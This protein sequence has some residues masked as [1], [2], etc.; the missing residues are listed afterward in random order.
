MISKRKNEQRTIFHTIEQVKCQA[1]HI[2][3]TTYRIHI[4]R[5]N[6]SLSKI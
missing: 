6:S 4:G 2:G 5:A 1:Y 3:A